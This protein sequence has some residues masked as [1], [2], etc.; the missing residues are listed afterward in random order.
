M[1][2]KKGSFIMA[3]DSFLLKCSECGEENY[4]DNKNKKN[5]PDKIQKKKYCPKCKK[6]TIHKEK[7]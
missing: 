2:I 4:I 5:N 6:M 3:R 7:K 1:S